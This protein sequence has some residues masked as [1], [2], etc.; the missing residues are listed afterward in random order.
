MQISA[1]ILKMRAEFYLDWVYSEFP[2][3]FSA[4]AE[5]G[6]TTLEGKPRR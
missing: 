2:F 4:E 1:F 5:A 6:D 3:A